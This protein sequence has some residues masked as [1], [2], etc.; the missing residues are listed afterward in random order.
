LSAYE[1]DLINYFRAQGKG[2]PEKEFHNLRTGLANK[3]STYAVN[4]SVVSFCQQ[5][6]P[7]IDQALAMDSAKFQRWAKHAFP[8]APTTRQMCKKTF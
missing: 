6:A 4:T 3:I 7:R 2:N 5:F 8:D 1:S